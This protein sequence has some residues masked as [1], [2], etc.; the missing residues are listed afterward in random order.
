MYFLSSQLLFLNCLTA[1]VD[2][3]N[4]L[5]LGFDIMAQPQLVFEEESGPLFFSEG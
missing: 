2:N 5:F 3:R 1:K 4:V